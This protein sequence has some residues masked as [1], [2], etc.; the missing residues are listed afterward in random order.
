MEAT[1]EYYQQLH[2]VLFTSIYGIIGLNSL[3]LFLVIGS[4]VFVHYC[5]LIF[6]LTAHYSLPFFVDM[7]PEITG[8]VSVITAMVTVLGSL[9]F[10][11]SFLGLSPAVHARWVRYFQVLQWI[12]IA[13]I[14]IQLINIIGF[15]SEDISDMLSYIAALAALLGI[16]SNL[17]VGAWMWKSLRYARLYL[18]TNIPMIL[19]ALTY[20]I[21]WFFQSSGQMEAGVLIRYLIS[22]GMAFQMILFS[23]FV[24]YKM[25]NAEKDK[26]E[27]EKDINM[28][29]SQEIQT[30]T[31]QMAL[32]KDEMEDQRNKLRELN[33]LKNK[34]FSLVAHDLRNPLHHLSSLVELMESHTVS[35]ETKISISKQTKMEVSDSIAVIDRL[36]HWTYKQ[37]DGI[38]VQKESFDLSDS[39]KEV[40]KELASLADS[41]K[42]KIN[43]EIECGPICF[44]V[45]MMR[46]VLRN[47]LSNAIKFSHEEG[48]IW[49]S[50]K[51]NIGDVVLSVRDEGLGMNPEWY[52]E[53]IRLGR[54][55]VKE[56]TKGEK[57]KGFGLLI[58]KDFVEMNDATLS[59]ES[60]SGVGTTFTIT[61]H[62]PKSDKKQ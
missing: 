9:L 5:I 48:N 22:S 27:L 10:T 43:A 42:V 57:G 16:A 39:V 33:E 19:A 11:V 60:S 26:L 34:L 35:T 58:T 44:D 14:G 17:V 24:G 21:I 30:Q 41:K 36:L 32:A 55:A 1:T 50:C 49:I 47:L 13:I 38:N 53:L 4:R 56:G 29:L 6:G 7:H 20:T 40:T 28:K 61:L 12:A 59:C 62:R 15:R 25:K 45:D 23:V 46:V 51:D 37:L 54:P 8:Q 31:R 18:L 3:L 2:N 52:D